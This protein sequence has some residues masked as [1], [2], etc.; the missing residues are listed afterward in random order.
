MA[1]FDS[2]PILQHLAHSS[3]SVSGFGFQ[4]FP[5]AVSFANFSSIP[6]K[7]K[8]LGAY[9]PRT[10]FLLFHRDNKIHQNLIL[11]LISCYRLPPD[12]FLTDC[13]VICCPDFY[14]AVVLFHAMYH[15]VYSSLLLPS[16]RLGR[17]TLRQSSGVYCIR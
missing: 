7:N 12:Y 16:Q 2:V 9:T 17:Y 11:S 4:K 10:L 14:E 13:P 6:N 5:F 1:I 3:L 8:S 15:F